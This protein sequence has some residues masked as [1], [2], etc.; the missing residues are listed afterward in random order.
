MTVTLP[1][2]WLFRAVTAIMIWL[3]LATFT[4]TGAEAQEPS[5]DD[6]R[7]VAADG[8]V[9]TLDAIDPASRTAGLLALYT[10]SFGDTTQT[11]QYGAEA[12]LAA[13]DDPQVYEVTY[14][15]T[16]WEYF[17]GE[18]Q[19]PGDNP[20]PDD[21]AVLSAAP[22]GDPDVRAFIRDH[23]AVGDRI[24]V[25]IP[26]SRTATTDIDAIDPTAATNPPGVDPGTGECYPGCRGANQLVVY[27][28][29]HGETTGTNQYGYEVTV[30]DGRIVGVGG[31][32]RQIPDGGY[33]IS[34]HGTEASWLQANTIVGALVE[35]DPQTMTVTVTIDATAYLFT[36]EQAIQRAETAITAAA[37]NC[38]DVPYDEAEQ[39]LNEAEQILA[40]AQTALDSGAEQ[41]AVDLAADATAAA[42]R[43][44]TLSRRSVPVE[45]RGI[46]VR[47]TETTTDGIAATLDRLQRAGINH[48]YLETFWNGATIFPSDAA[49]DAGVIAQMPLFADAGIDALA[50][51]IEQAHARDIEVHAWVEDFFVG[52][53]ASVGVGPILSVHPDWAAVEYEDVEAVA[54]DGE[55]RPSSREPGYYFLDPAIP[56]A[57]QYLLSVYAE[58]LSDY[59]IDGI[60]LD[61]I[62]YPVSLPLESSFSYSDYSRAAFAEVSGVDPYTLTP[63]DAEWVEWVEWRQ[64]NITS[65]VGEVRGLIDRIDPNA[66][67]SAAVFPDPFD[68]SIRKLQDWAAWAD[69]GWLDV[70]NGMSFGRSADD[71]AAD[72]AAMR[73]AVGDQA[74]IYTGIYS[75]FLGLPPQTLVEQVEAVRA[76]GGHGVALFSELQLTDAQVDALAHGPFRRP[77]LAP[78]SQPVD[79]VLT[80]VSDLRDRLDEHYADC[81][82]RKT[83][84]RTDRTLQRIE[85]LLADPNRG[86][87]VAAGRQLGSAA[88]RIDTG[89][90][91]GV[92]LVTDLQRYESILAWADPGDLNRG[93]RG[94]SPASR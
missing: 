86:R 16:V 41:T 23:V 19:R 25:I 9:A 65:F 47:P 62:R 46:W 90:D 88:D 7:V 6:P 68:S 20:I 60:N 32:D 85:R 12:V 49:T 27:S 17:A 29:A 58:M 55:P 15:C 66:T 51:W 45:G 54:A 21:G 14:V 39:S 13:T 78:H 75:P 3:A 81:L 77:A 70:L 43:A 76:A 35:I 30:V 79:A 83:V 64:D 82:D 71:V 72:T 74:L 48:V 33:V 26:I 73:R 22:G 28:D 69:N 36:A 18:C 42:E 2:Q 10:P 63:D 52:N 50:V 80:G 38:L 93:P 4:A 31:N 57:R 5:D 24:Q 94:R 92:H 8:T 89:T 34:G 84:R 53:D 56:A 37:D 67:L 11:N 40:D 59:D 91:W 61:Y 44:W 1:T 87:V